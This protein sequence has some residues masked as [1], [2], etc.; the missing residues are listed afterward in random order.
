MYY[1]TLHCIGFSQFVWNIKNWDTSEQ[2]VS[3]INEALVIAKT[4]YK[5]GTLQKLTL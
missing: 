5:W 3:N 1:I 4:G 2:Y